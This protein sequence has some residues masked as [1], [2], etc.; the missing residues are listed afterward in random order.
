MKSA[1][2][3]D[4]LVQNREVMIAGVIALSK[5]GYLIFIYDLTHDREGRSMS[6]IPARR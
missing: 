1:A 4:R 2:N 6:R 3:V 5:I